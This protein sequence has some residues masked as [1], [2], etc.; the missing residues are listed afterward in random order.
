M[1][2]AGAKPLQ[3]PG[4]PE[5]GS[6]RDNADCDGPRGLGQ[7]EGRAGDDL[8]VGRIPLAAPRTGRGGE[9][10]S[11]SEAL[12]APQ[13]AGAGAVGWEAGGGSDAACLSRT[14][15]AGRDCPHFGCGAGGR[16][17]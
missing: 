13:V 3:R 1:G 7:R 4:S 8:G 14:H 12:A 9:G 10:R 6:R 17:A 5:G 16:E 11:R 15:R 2:I